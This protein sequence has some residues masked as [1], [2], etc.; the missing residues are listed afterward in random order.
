MPTFWAKNILLTHSDPIFMMNTLYHEQHHQHKHTENIWALRL[1]FGE[2][3]YFL[4]WTPYFICQPC[5]KSKHV[6]N[7][8]VKTALILLEILKQFWQTTVE[9]SAVFALPTRKRWRET[10]QTFKLFFANITTLNTVTI[11]QKGITNQ[12]VPF[13]LIMQVLICILDLR[14]SRTHDMNL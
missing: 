14:V 7:Q 1:H 4:W 10:S 13:S 2:G 8:F 6:E 12:N 11:C 3:S 5:R 9:L